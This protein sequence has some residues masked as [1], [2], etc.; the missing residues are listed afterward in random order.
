MNTFLR[1]FSVIGLFALAA[2]SGS[3]VNLPPVAS[4]PVIG[5][6][7]GIFTVTGGTFEI[8]VAPLDA[9]GNLI[10]G[11]VSVNN[12]TFIDVKAAAV[13]KPTT[14]LATASVTPS[15]VDVISKRQNIPATLVINFDASG[16]MELG[17]APTDPERLRVVAG[18]KLVDTLGDNDQA[19]ILDFS[20]SRKTS[21]FRASRLLQAFTS[22]KTLLKTAIDKVAGEGGTPL[23]ASVLDALN[24]LNSIS[25]S[26]KAI[27]L[28]TDGIPDGDSASFT[29][30]LTQAQSQ[31]VPIF[32]IGLGTN[33]DFTKLQNL[34]QQTG[35]TFAEARDANALNTV[36]GNIGVGISQGRVIVT[37]KGQFAQTL[38]SSGDYIV[39]GVLQT[40]IGGNT[41]STPFSFRVTL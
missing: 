22:D 35:G 20:T 16:S 4:A 14:T 5:V 3:S 38:A 6:T 34:A 32:T 1:V 33:I 7:P 39:S 37:G 19:A 27:V 13:A 40:T 26:N 24:L 10:S 11:G 2:C 36:F 18:K 28:L 21:G 8:A 31:T 25:V 12:F 30:A 41:V 15:K 9:N 23:Y 29:D 17:F